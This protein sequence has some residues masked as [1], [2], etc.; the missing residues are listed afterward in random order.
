M[1][2]S[3]PVGIWPIPQSVRLAQGRGYPGFPLLQ[4]KEK[5]VPKD[6]LCSPRDAAGD[7]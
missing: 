6:G 4:K 1:H 7:Q 3:W 2:D 5:A